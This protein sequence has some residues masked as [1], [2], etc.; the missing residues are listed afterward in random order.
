LEDDAEVDIF[1]DMN[2]KYTGDDWKGLLAL[3]EPKNLSISWIMMGARRND[4]KFER[5]SSAPRNR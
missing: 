5:L 4:Y 1:S 2:K 3:S